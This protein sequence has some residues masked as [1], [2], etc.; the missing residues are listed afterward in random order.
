MLITNQKFTKNFEGVVLTIF[1]ACVPVGAEGRYKH[2]KRCS[3][4]FQD[5]LNELSILLLVVL[6]K[7]T[8]LQLE[9]LN[10]RQIVLHSIK[11]M[12]IER[13]QLFLQLHDVAFV[14][15]VEQCIQLLL[16]HMWIVKFTKMKINFL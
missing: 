9:F 3:Q 2:V 1:L 12:R 6:S 7:F 8:Q 15:S 14:D 4:N 11:G 16:E 5:Q 10:T 13:D